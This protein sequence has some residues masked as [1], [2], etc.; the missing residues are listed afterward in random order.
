M[1]TMVSV[2]IVKVKAVKFKNK[3]VQEFINSLRSYVPL[4]SG[5]RKRAH[6]ADKVTLLW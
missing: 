3:I 4:I 6:K 5:A 2:D 1:F